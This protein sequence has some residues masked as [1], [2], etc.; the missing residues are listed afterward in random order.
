MGLS[1]VLRRVGGLG[2]GKD[3]LRGESHAGAWGRDRQLKWREQHK[4]RPRG[5]SLLQRRSQF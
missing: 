2:A 1:K 4:R 5:V 3:A